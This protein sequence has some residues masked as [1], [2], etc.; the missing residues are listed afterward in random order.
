[1]SL[2]RECSA[3]RATPAAL[4]IATGLV[5]AGCGSGDKPAAETGQ[6]SAAPSGS[7]SNQSASPSDPSASPSVAAASGPVR[8][9][10]VGVSVTGDLG[11]KPALTVP[12][13][14]APTG[15]L[16]E[17]LVAGTGKSVAKGQTLVANYLGQTWSPKDGTVNVFDNSYDRQVPAG[18]PIGVGRVIKGW[19]EALVNQKIG[20]RVLLSIPPAQAYGTDPKAANGLGGQTLLFVVDILGGL[21]PDAAATGAAV[22]EIPAGYPKVSSK[23]GARPSITSV[24]GVTT[25]AQNKST[26]LV[27]GSGPSIDEESTLAVQVV[28]TDAA[29]GKQTQQ[30]WGQAIEIVPAKDVLGLASALKGQKVGSRVLVVTGGP[31]TQQS[32]VVIVDVVG[33]Y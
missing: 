31:S 24:T 18:F 19:D 23:P 6:T 15:L 25:T 1:M 26:M 20:S 27:R 11:D 33:Q 9:T 7:P 22:T 12:G 30:T 8:K 29:T 3:L 2:R 16:T 17:V 21:D 4:L 28:Q 32:G 14:A 13:S 10:K 5:L